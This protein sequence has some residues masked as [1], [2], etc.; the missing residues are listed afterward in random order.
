MKTMDKEIFDQQNAFELGQEAYAQY[1]V[2]NSY[3]N[4]L[5]VPSQCPVFLA[6]VTFDPA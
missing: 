6:N 2:G 3:L 5:T 1:F 4:P